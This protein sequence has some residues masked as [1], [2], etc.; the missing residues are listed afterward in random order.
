LLE[1][2]DAR[3]RVKRAVAGLLAVAVATI[4][5]IGVLLIWH[6]VRRGRMIRDRLTPPRRVELPDFDDES[7]PRT[8][9]EPDG[10][11]PP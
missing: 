10:G 7:G 5:V 9:D 6:L 2:P 4:G 1:R 8:G 3:P 11:G